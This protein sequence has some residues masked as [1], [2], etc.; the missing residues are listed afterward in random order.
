MVLTRSEAQRWS[1][2]CT[3]IDDSSSVCDSV[4]LISILLFL[5]FRN[6][7]ASLRSRDP[8]WGVRDLESVI[9]AASNEGLEL[10][11]KIEMPANNL[12]LI[13]QRKK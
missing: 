2:I 6:F 1:P 10:I 13:F 12:S 8:T 11:E 4:V 3:L 9:E 5:E 7:D